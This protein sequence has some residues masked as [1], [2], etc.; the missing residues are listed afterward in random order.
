MI[1]PYIIQNTFPPTAALHLL[2]KG[3]CS[4]SGLCTGH[5]NNWPRHFCCLLFISI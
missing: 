1:S 4:L 2:E 5:T 3:S